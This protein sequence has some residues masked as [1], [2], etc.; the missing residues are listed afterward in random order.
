MCNLNF[1]ILKEMCIQQKWWR[2][3]NGDAENAGLGKWWTYADWNFT[4]WKMQGWK[5]T[6]RVMTF[7]MTL[8]VAELNGT[9]TIGFWRFSSWRG[10]CAQSA[11]YIVCDQLDLAIQNFPT[12]SIVTTSA[13]FDWNGPYYQR[14]QHQKTKAEEKP[15]EWNMYRVACLTW[16]IE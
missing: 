1:D 5:L 14:H 13:A 16:L 4:D 3:Y 15:S 7:R 6:D 10:R 2:K 12:S 8:I 9:Q 11:E